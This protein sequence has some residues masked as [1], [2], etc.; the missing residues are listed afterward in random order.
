M[1]ASS[2]VYSGLV[3]GSIISRRFGRRMCMFAMSIWGIVAAIVVI[4]ASHP[5]HILVG[6]V[7]NCE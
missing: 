2:N 7:I 4:T 1:I 5:T 6:R 3:V